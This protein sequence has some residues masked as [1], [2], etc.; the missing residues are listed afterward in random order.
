MEVDEFEQRTKEYVLLVDLRQLLNLQL[1]GENLGIGADVG[2]VHLL[3]SSL[4]AISRETGLQ[5][6]GY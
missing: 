5:D 6:I 1:H 4:L 2:D 3:T